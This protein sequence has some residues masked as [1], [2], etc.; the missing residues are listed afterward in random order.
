MR[1]LFQMMDNSSPLEGKPN[2]NGKQ[3]GS[4]RLINQKFKKYGKIQ[5]LR[6][7]IPIQKFDT[8][9]IDDYIPKQKGG[10]MH[11]IQ[12]ERKYMYDYHFK[13]KTARASP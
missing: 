8:I 9:R 11:R 10:E 2:K 5:F 13:R 6:S 12:S 1:F 4:T 7:C 3:Q